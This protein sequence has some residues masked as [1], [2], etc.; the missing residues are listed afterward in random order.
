[1]EIEAPS[2][3]V[4]RL[5]LDV[6]VLGVPGH[7]RSTLVARTPPF[8][9]CS[10]EVNDNLLPISHEIDSFGKLRVVVLESADNVAV[11]RPLHVSGGPFDNV[12]MILG[13]RAP[14]LDVTF[15]HK[16]VLPDEVCLKSRFPGA[17]RRNDFYIDLLPVVQVLFRRIPPQPEALN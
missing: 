10:P 8:T 3:R 9:S 16:L 15:I 13:A 14:V 17:E 11:D 5:H 4:E 1:M 2:V 7:V 6:V 12:L